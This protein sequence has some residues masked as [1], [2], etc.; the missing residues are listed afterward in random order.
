MFPS[1]LDSRPFFPQ[2]TPQQTIKE[3]AISESK[4]HSRMH[5]ATGN[6]PSTPARR[7]TVQAK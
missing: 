7:L 3:T 1:N 5:L 6:V 2:A 4:A